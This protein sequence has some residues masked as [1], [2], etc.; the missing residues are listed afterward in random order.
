[1]RVDG[2][3]IRGLPE[4]KTGQWSLP[5]SRSALGLE[6]EY[7]TVILLLCAWWTEKRRK[8]PSRGGEGGRT[9]CVF[10]SGTY[11]NTFVFAWTTSGCPRTQWRERISTC[12][13]QCHLISSLHSELGSFLRC[14]SRRRWSVA[15]CILPTYNSRSMPCLKVSQCFVRPNG[16]KHFKFVL[17]SP[18]QEVEFESEAD[19][20]KL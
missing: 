5:R 20:C 3:R 13:R 6:L 9:V 19:N 11:T 10:S 2:A 12:P 18:C 4:R 14:D 15:H 1:V 16:F 17:H 8:R 7:G